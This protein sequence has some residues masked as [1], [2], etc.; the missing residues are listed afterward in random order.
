[1]RSWSAQ[2]ITSS[3]PVDVA[4]GRSYSSFGVKGHGLRVEALACRAEAYSGFEQEK[5]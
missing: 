1:M 2:G 5:P 3:A 4:Q